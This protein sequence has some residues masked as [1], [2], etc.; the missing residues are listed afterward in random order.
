[1]TTR[2]TKL[3]ATPAATRGEYVRLAIGAQALVASGAGGEGVALGR[4]TSGRILLVRGVPNADF[5]VSL[6][7]HGPVPL[8]PVTVLGQPSYVY[9][10]ADLAGSRSAMS[11]VPFADGPGRV[12][13]P[14]NRWELRAAGL[15]DSQLAAYAQAIESSSATETPT[16]TTTP[17]MAALEVSLAQ[18]AAQHGAQVNR[19]LVQI[20]ASGIF[21]AVSFNVR[22][23]STHPH[24]DIVRYAP[25]EK[26]PVG[27]ASWNVVTDI[28]L[29]I[30]GIV[31]PGTT[32]IS[33]VHL[34]G[35]VLPDFAVT[36]NYNAGN[37]T[38]LIAHTSD[39]WHALSFRVGKAALVDEVINATIG[40]NTITEA[41]DNCVP[42]CAHGSTIHHTYRYNPSTDAMTATA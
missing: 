7:A 30:G 33:A 1:V 37:A 22:S 18:F 23:Q 15:T 5:S 28:T 8:V 2:L 41:I 11:R 4:T 6:Y 3:T 14:C 9:P 20:T 21:A 17:S 29:D 10:A 16:T 24:V 19:S 36:V 13:H 38:A 40:A 32:A 31:E 34:T 26:L 35:T 39:H 42:D 27:K 25:T 12:A